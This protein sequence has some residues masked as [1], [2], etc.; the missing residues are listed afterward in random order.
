MSEREPFAR[1]VMIAALAVMVIATIGGNLIFG[2]PPHL[3]LVTSLGIAYLALTT[4]GWWWAERRGPRAAAAM[5]AVLYALT[6]A[7]LW[8]SDQQWFLLVFPPLLFAVLYA[9]V[10]WAIAATIGIL[11]FAV[12]L[13]AHPGASL[14][15]IYLRSTGFLPA[16]ILTIAFSWVMVR[17]RNAR[18]E[19]AEL[20]ATRERNRIARD[21]HDSVGH[22]LT[23]VHVQIE[24]ARAIVAR[25][26]A[27]A[28]ECLVR[29]QGLARDGL[30]EL[31][32]SVSLLRAGAAADRPFG[33]SLAKLVD[34]SRQAGLDAQLA[35]EGAPRAL[36]P[37][38]ELA[39]FRAAQEALTNVARHARATRARCTLAYRDDAIHLRVADD[40][41]GAAATDGG[42]GLDGMRERLAAVGG[43]VDV[44]T[45]PGAGF[46]IDV[47]VPA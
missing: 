13:N 4:G 33:V 34:D 14:T 15:Q 46:T 9:G 44:R 8:A 38:I 41:A 23:V 1:P 29:A 22:Y 43:S 2:E 31:R 26:P 21:I 28:D 42:F 7:I 36:P 35:I 17:E 45:A 32:R 19:L 27:G 3:A 12:L 20:A 6:L 47:R 25:D 40:G 24:A 16:A 11:A 37:A 30:G 10:A 5:V 18:L 39:I